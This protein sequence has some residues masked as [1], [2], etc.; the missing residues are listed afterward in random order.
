MLK[1][2]EMRGIYISPLSIPILA[3]AEIPSA[4][5]MFANPLINCS[6]H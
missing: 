3:K 1:T 6:E 4:L 5:E 2:S